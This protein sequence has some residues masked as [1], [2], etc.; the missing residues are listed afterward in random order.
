MEQIKGPDYL[1]N[2]PEKARV[3]DDLENKSKQG[4]SRRV[5]LKG[6]VAL[7]VVFGI[8]KFFNS[9]NDED[10]YRNLTERRE[11]KVE[12]K[13]TEEQKKIK[14]DDDRIIGKTIEE[15]L[16]KGEKIV[17]NKETKNA[18]RQKWEK[19]YSKRPE[20]CS[21]S[22]KE[23]GKNH[24]G[25]LES[26]E[27]MQP[28]LSAM[29]AEFNKIG[30]PENYV[31]LAIPESH[32]NLSAVSRARA[33]GPFQFTKG[34]AK[35]F[36]LFI[37]DVID[38]RC[39]PIES[40]LACA[41]HLKYGYERFNNNWDLAFADYNGGFTN[42]Y[43]KF[44]PQKKDRNY[45]DYLQWREGRINKF[46]SKKHF[47]HKVESGQTLTR[48]AQLHKM[49]VAELMEINGMKDDKIKVNQILKISIKNSTIISKMS[50]SLENLNYPEKF[51]A[52][53]DVIEK[54]G[55]EGRFPAKPIK[56]DLKEV[57]EEKMTEFSHT[58]KK[59]EGLL[60]IA[61]KFRKIAKKKNS[62][63]NLSAFQIQSLIQRQN[64]ISDY[65]KIY[66]GQEL[67]VI[68]PLSNNSSLFQ[69]AQK[70]KIDIAE[71]SRLNPAISSTKKSLL[72]GMKVRVPRG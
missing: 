63:F 69:M 45:E 22:D 25:L 56:F 39:D 9:E 47:D 61:R 8:G 48:I 29:K 15:Q 52:V 37:D 28:W 27:R 51:Y 10:K 57:P 67:K 24:L 32:F 23:S 49:T 38:N 54:E 18:I 21:D 43:A 55:L 44:R 58:I 3:L 66:P 64:K 62:K 31:Y 53:L 71:L 68:L 65:R 46:I 30:V 4:I 14:E 60:A 1:T 36:K 11:E 5:L 26:M 17:L 13:P 12:D 72:A 19:S 70:F 33:V 34:T 50:D 6:A 2:R 42:K 7:G 16:M 40:A 59:G 20:N 41:K 35:L